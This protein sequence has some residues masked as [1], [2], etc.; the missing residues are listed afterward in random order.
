MKRIVTNIAVVALAAGSISAGNFYEEM[1]QFRTKEK[2]IYENWNKKLW[3]Q[4]GN[5][6]TYKPA[7]AIPAGPR[8]E[9]NSEPSALFKIFNASF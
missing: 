7:A 3:E 1:E 5:A 9:V 8:P 6:E 4:V 2:Q